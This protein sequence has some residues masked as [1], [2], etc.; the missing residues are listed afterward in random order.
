MGIRPVSY[1]HLGGDYPLWIGA[2]TPT[3]APYKVSIAGKLYATGAVISGDSTFE[4]TL[5]GVSG[6]FTRLNCVNDAGNAVGGISFGSDGRM[7]FDGDMYHQGTKEGRSLR[8]YTSDSVSYTHLDVYKRQTQY[9]VDVL[10]EC[11]FN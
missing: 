10:A 6:S 9:D 1:T 5:K 7:W 4:G 3:D 2:T 8:F 11:H